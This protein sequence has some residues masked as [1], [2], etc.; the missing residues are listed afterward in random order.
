MHETLPIGYYLNHNMKGSDPSCRSRIP[1]SLENS[2]MIG[3]LAEIGRATE[4]E[5]PVSCSVTMITW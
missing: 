3:N 5:S 4:A 1:L 2:I